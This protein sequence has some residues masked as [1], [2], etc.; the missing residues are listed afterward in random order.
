MHPEVKIRV[1]KLYVCNLY[2][3]SINNVSHQ[4]MNQVC[5][6]TYVH[7]KIANATSSVKII[8]VGIRILL[9]NL[10]LF[11]L[12]TTPIMFA[13]MASQ[14]DVVDLFKNKYGQ[15]EPFPEAVSN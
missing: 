3:H 13:M 4:F 2:R 8:Q 5:I 6:H 12:E 11:Q 9:H 10:F 1:Q 7:S 14:S 15:K